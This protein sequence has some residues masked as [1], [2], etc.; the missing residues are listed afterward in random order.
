MRAVTPLYR[1]AMIHS[2]ETEKRSENGMGVLLS[3]GRMLPNKNRA[4]LAKLSGRVTKMS[5]TERWTG[6]GV[7]GSHPPGSGA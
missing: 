7:S 5:W 4:G 2:D 6:A 3:V 1:F